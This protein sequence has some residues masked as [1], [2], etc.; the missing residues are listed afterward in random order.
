MCLAFSGILVSCA[1]P[2]QLPPPLH[3]L[4]PNEQTK[5][6]SELVLPARTHFE[7]PLNESFEAE[8]HI[9]HPDV[10]KWVSY[11]SGPGKER[12]ENVLRRGSLYKK[13]IHAILQKFQLPTNLYYL[14]LIESDFKVDA[15]SPAEAAGI[16][17]FMG[18][19]A[20]N[21]GLRINEFIDERRDPWRSTVAAAL[22]LR[23]LKNV[24]DSWFLAMCAYNAGESRIMNA[25]IRSGTRDFWQ[26]SKV[27]FIPRETRM[28]VPRF[29]AA[30]IVAEN[31]GRYGI[32]VIFPDQPKVVAVPVPSPVH[33]S[34]IAAKTGI[35]LA[36]LKNY[37][38]HILRNYTPPRVKSYRIWLPQGGGV[39]YASLADLETIPLKKLLPPTK[40]KRHYKLAHTKAKKHKRK[41]IKSLAKRN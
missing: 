26:L 14:A 5:T 32:N 29:L 6:D 9:D 40:A 34:S 28:Y 3:S 41:L 18:P 20:K 35:S 12:F 24:F 16:W 23:N 37:N 27:G 8:K 31:P 15:R 33:L 17:Q 10:Q 7:D 13:E 2:Q 22:Y 25:I 11:F 36:D 21:Y 39:N 1:T 30:L 19:T 4:E 38:P